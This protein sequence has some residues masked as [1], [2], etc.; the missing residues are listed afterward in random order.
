MLDFCSWKPL[1][2]NS[3]PPI[4]QNTTVAVV[5]VIAVTMIS[6]FNA[7]QLRKSSNIL[8]FFVNLI[9]AQCRVLRESAWVN[10]PA[11]E[12]QQGDI[13]QV[14]MGQKVPADT[15]LLTCNDLQVHNS[16]FTGE[17]EQVHCST[18]ARRRTRSRPEI[19]SEGTTYAEWLHQSLRC[20]RL[21][22]HDCLCAHIF[23]CCV[24]S[25]VLRPP[26]LRG[27]GHW[28]CSVCRRC[29][30]DGP[31]QPRDRCDQAK[32]KTAPSAT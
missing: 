9:T 21:D 24:L 1:S 6:L 2:E 3:A 17:A 7:Y 10:M 12:L 25:R 5:I 8:A 30:C 31:H 15:R 28:C 29:E 18:S 26:V 23:L 11:A 16:P 32:A 14:A 22:A 27:R 4:S 13:V 20:C 19:W